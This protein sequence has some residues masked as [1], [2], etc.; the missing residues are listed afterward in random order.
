MGVGM[1]RD[2]GVWVNTSGGRA[3]VRGS[4][5]EEVRGGDGH[6]RGVRGHKVDLLLVCVV[7]WHVGQV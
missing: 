3:P 5:S 7:A 1:A 4:G 6:R 2:I